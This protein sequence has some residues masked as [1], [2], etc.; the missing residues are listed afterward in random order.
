MSFNCMWAH[1]AVGNLPYMR[2]SLTGLMF[3]L[4]TTIQTSIPMQMN[5]TAWSST[6]AEPEDDGMP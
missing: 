2:E 4:Y 5:P 3:H 1:S 6:M